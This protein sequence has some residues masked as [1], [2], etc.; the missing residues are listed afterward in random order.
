MERLNARFTMS[1]AARMNNVFYSAEQ[2]DGHF[3]MGA[4]I[5]IIEGTA[6]A[7]KSACMDYIWKFSG[8][9]LSLI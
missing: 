5:S 4:A 1:V 6:L 2:L 8:K 7:Q 9:N 3:T